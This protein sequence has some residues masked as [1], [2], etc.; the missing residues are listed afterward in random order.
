MGAPGGPASLLVPARSPV[1]ELAPEAKVAAAVGFT[2]AVVLTPRE[3][4]W[5]FA[6]DLAAVLAVLALA[7]VPAGVVLRRAR[8][9]LPFVAFAA[10]LPF[11]GGDPRV[12]LAGLA[13]SEPGLW[14]AW[15]VLAKATL[16]VLAAVALVATTPV[17]ELL[18]GL[19]RL[20]VPAPLV[21]I[22]GAMVRYLDV[23]AG[24]AA[25][26]DVA[27]RSRGYRGRW[28]WQARAVAAGA[29]ALF[30]RAYERG[31]RVHLAMA[32][33]GFDG[34]AVPVVAVLDGGRR[35]PALAAALLPAMAVIGAVVA[36]AVG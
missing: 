13:L 35:R 5:A 19:R 18:A 25:R 21:A 36:A 32:S 17:P 23:L 2:A 3:A 9:E 30:V 31:E 14:A 8:V 15:S 24:E 27:R 22:A 34:S 6:I 33:R 20:R 1:H 11:A 10:L 7:R 16:G 28:L 26:M 12:E 4:V 29:G